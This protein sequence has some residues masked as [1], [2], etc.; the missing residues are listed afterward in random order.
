MDLTN[1]FV[2]AIMPTLEQFEQM[3]HDA[4]ITCIQKLNVLG[5]DVF[6]K[7]YNLDGPLDEE[8]RGT[9]SYW[10]F[11]TEEEIDVV[12]KKVKDLKA[13]GEYEKWVKEHD[14]SGDTGILTIFF[15]KPIETKV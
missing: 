2:E 6:K 8:W 4:G 14:H 3:F 15:C 10:S 5:S 9:S 13:R 7:Y 11:A 12:E 1:R